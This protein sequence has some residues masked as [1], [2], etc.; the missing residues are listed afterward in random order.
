MAEQGGALG[1]DR[2]HHRAHVIHPLLE[3]RHA[4]DTVGRACAALVEPDDAHAPRELVDPG[5]HRLVVELHRREVETAREDEIERALAEDA[6]GDVDVAARRVPSS[7]PSTRQS[8][9]SSAGERKRT[10]GSGGD[11]VKA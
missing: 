2:I 1:A 10:V 4:A 6:V 7:E 5:A 9:S 3:R 11:G 8:R